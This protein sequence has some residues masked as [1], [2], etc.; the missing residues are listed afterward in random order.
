MTTSG[1]SA[2]APTATLMVANVGFLQKDN[3]CDILE[4]GDDTLK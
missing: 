2:G 3:D 1:A 4:P